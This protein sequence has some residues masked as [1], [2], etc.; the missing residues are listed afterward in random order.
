MSWKGKHYWIIGASAGLGEALANELSDAGAMLTISARSNSALENVAKDLSSP[1]QIAPCDIGDSESIKSALKKA[2]EET[3]IDGIIFCAGQYAPMT[4]ETWDAEKAEQ[5][6]DVNFTGSARVLGEY[7]PYMKQKNTGHIVMIGSLSGFKGIPGGSIYA[8]SKAG[9]MHLTEGLRADL[10]PKKFKVQLINPGFIKTRL[11]DKNT[12]KMPFIMSP[13]KAA[14]RTIKAMESNRFQTNFPKRF[15]FIF[16][17]LGILPNAAYF[18][19][20]QKL[21]K[22]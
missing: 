22:T 15:A 19:V 13:D 5:I 7:L 2:T 20:A 11:T 4:A 8:A 6:S 9:M 1:C 10:D 16:Q 21:L 14:K 17:L 18:P 3:P 12:F